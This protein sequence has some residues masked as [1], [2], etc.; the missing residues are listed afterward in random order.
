MVVFLTDGLPTVGTVDVNQILKNVKDANRAS[1]RVF[2]FGVGYDVNTT[3]LDR[4]VADNRGSGD[5]IEPNEDLE[6]KVSN[7]FARVNYPVLSD[8]RLDLGGVEADLMYP[9]ALPDLFRGS[10]LTVVGRYK[11]TVNEA[12]VR[13]TGRVGSRTETFLF[14]GRRFASEAGA[15]EFLP[16]LWA[17]RRVGYLLEQIRL[18]GENREL[19]DEIV[20]LGTRYGIVTP[21]TSY[22]V[23]EDM[24]DLARRPMPAEQARMLGP[25]IQARKDGIVSGTGAGAGVGPGAVGRSRAEKELAKSDVAVDFEPYLSKVKT[26]GGKTFHLKNG[27]WTDADYN[28]N[29]KVPTIDLKFGSDQFFDLIAKKPKLGEFFALGEKVVVVFEGKVYRVEANG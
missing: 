23:T 27:V 14:D 10:Q 24:R 28:E 1:V 25:A 16:R 6:V 2:S 21:Y 22:L 5:Y 13:L 9:R 12:T 4:L 15:N 3:L 8:L 7:F 26:V 11:N 19:K 20:A 17:I 29:L 18:N